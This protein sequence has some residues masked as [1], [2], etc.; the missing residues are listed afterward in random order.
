MQIIDAPALTRTENP[1]IQDVADLIAAGEGKAG[2]IEVPAADANKARV[3]FAKAANAAGKTARLVTPLDKLT[4]DENGNV[5]IVFVLTGKHAPR[6]GK[7][8]A[9]TTT[10]TADET[11]SEP[12]AETANE[13]VAESV[14]EP[15]AET[16][17]RSRK[18]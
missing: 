6:R 11:A 4:A 3:K 5:Q 12:V 8:A 16:P 7:A 17:S 18:R 1:Y 14:A 9:E 10:E 13:P 2:A 15:V